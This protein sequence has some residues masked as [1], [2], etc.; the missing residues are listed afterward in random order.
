M[1]NIITIILSVCLISSVAFAEDTERN[2]S[3]SE[4]FSKVAGGI[5][6]IALAASMVHL[7]TKRPSRQVEYR[8]VYRPHRRPAYRPCQRHREYCGEYN[9]PYGRW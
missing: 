5:M 6:M 1:K 3:K 8:P 7:A 4:A 9:R 2:L